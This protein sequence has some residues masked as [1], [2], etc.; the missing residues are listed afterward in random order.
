MT[1]PDP[2]RSRVATLLSLR[3]AG[4]AVLGLGFYRYA[5]GGGAPNPIAAL[6]MLVGFTLLL[7]I[8][9]LLVRRWK[10]PE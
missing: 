3:L 7:A 9:W 4:A 2:A 1:E 10:A 6:I 8:P 5:K